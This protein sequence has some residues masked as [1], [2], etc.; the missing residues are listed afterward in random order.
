MPP[1]TREPN[2][3]LLVEGKNSEQLMSSKIKESVHEIESL[4]M[5]QVLSVH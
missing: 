3:K 4:M 2:L 1:S 5:S